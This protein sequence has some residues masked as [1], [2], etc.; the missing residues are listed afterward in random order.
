MCVY[1]ELQLRLSA[2]ENEFRKV[3][4]I[5]QY[6]A[7]LAKDPPTHFNSKLPR[8]SQALIL[9]YGLRVSYQLTTLESFLFTQFPFFH[10][11][12]VKSCRQQASRACLKQV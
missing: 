2:I 6:N 7:V 12:P 11:L 8:M 4:R 5:S 3:L 9:N 1:F 10:W